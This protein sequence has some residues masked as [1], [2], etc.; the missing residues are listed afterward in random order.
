MFYFNNLLFHALCLI[1]RKKMHKS[2]GENENKRKKNKI[3]RQLDSFER[4]FV[5]FSRPVF[6]LNFSLVNG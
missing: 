3:N 4:S 2:R 1:L 6:F 5:G